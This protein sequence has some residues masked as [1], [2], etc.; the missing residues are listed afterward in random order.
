MFTQ[1]QIEQLEEP[2]D[3]KHIKP[4]KQYGPKGDYIEGWHAIAEANRIFGFDGWS[5]EIIDRK[6]LGECVNQKGNTEIAYE[7]VVSVTAGGVTRQDIGY[8]SGASSKPLDAY[9]GAMKEAVTDA[10]KRALRT[11][12]DQFGLALYD[13]EKKNVVNSWAKKAS[14]LIDNISK[15]NTY[16]DLQELAKSSDMQSLK[17]DCPQAEKESV[18]SAYKKKLNSLTNRK[19]RAA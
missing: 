12:G 5:Y 13:K 11:F 7:C 18:V 19:D 15:I 17:T 1:D 16:E 6:K 4:A 8:G 3:T 9:E 10:L 14:E 2:L